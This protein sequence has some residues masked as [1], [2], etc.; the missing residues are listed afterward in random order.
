MPGCSAS[1]RG[2]CSRCTRAS[3]RPTGSTRRTRSTRSAGSRPSRRCRPSSRCGASML[4]R[5]RTPANRLFQTQFLVLTYQGGVQLRRVASLA[6]F[7][8]VGS[9]QVIHGTL[10][11]G[12]FVAFNS[13][14]A[15]AN[16]PVLVLLL[17][18]DELQIARILIGRLDDAI[19][20]QPEQD[21]D[22]SALLPPSR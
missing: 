6:A 3:R 19:D 22:R 21:A 1:R 10:T 18:W 15:L 7:L 4:A 14:V 8:A 11:V 16:G 12:E 9:A 17:L 2:G 5:F 13:L 20:Q